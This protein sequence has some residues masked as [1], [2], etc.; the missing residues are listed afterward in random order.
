MYP[1]HEEEITE[2]FIEDN[3]RGKKLSDFQ[4]LWAITY[5]HHLPADVKQHVTESL[6]KRGKNFT[7]KFTGSTW[8]RRALSKNDSD[9]SDETF[10]LVAQNCGRPIGDLIHGDHDR[11]MRRHIENELFQRG[12]VHMHN[13]VGQHYEP[14]ILWTHLT[15]NTPLHKHLMDQDG[16][17]AN[18][19]AI[20]ND[21]RVAAGG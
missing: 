1:T 10:A 8:P 12:N 3:F 21:H 17:Y 4:I 2:E 20:M 6:R 7:L 11:D 5:G 9:W 19:H 13:L 16:E 14:R 15:K 18:L